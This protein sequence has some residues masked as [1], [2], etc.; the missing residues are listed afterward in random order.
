MTDFRL[1]DFIPYLLNNAAESTSRAFSAH[2]RKQYG[3]SRAQWR[4]MAHLGG[5][6]PLTASDIC[7]RAY[8]EKSKVSRAVTGLEEAGLLRRAPSA[9]DRRAE[10]LSLTARG[11]EIHDDLAAHALAFSDAL[12]SRLGTERMAR[13]AEILRDLTQEPAD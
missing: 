10:L 9:T 7:A 6:G 13:L 5:N 11:K 4:I 8:L 12:V 3:L 1:D 2:Y